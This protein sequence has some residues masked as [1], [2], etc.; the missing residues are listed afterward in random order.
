MTTNLMPAP[1]RDHYDPRALGGPSHAHLVVATLPCTY[2]LGDVAG[3]VAP[4]VVEVEVAVP[5][6]RLTWW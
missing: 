2:C 5:R 4:D 1:S 6:L 3:E